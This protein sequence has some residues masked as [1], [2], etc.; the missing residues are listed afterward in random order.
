MPIFD[1]EPT[2]WKDLQRMVGQMFS[3]MDC[4][5]RVGE[6]VGLVRGGKEIDVYVLDNGVAPPAQYLCECK[7]WKKAIPQEVVHSF[8]TVV[9]DYGSNIG[10]IIS[11]G[12]FQPGAQKAAVN[13]NVQLVTFVELQDIFFDR[14][15][16]AW[17]TDSCRMQTDYFRIG[18]TREKYPRLNG[19]RS[20]SNGS[21]SSSKLTGRCSNSGR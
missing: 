15:R 4:V 14:W 5:V 20:T 11:S 18:I 16:V 2:D 6:R 7:L 3:E 9:A 19:I 12:R 17:A 21:R 13:T 8:R 10:F 1:R